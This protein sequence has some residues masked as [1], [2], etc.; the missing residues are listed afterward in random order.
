MRDVSFPLDVEAD[1][2]EKCSTSDVDRSALFFDVLRCTHGFV[3]AGLYGRFLNVAMQI[4]FVEMYDG[5]LETSLVDSLGSDG[6]HQHDEGGRTAQRRLH[7]EIRKF[8][9]D[10]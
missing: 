6:F 3:K 8:I 7:L 10:H 1:G 9:L 5:G 2:D 4:I